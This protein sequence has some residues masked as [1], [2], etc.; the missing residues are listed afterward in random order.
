MCWQRRQRF[1]GGWCRKA[2]EGVMK[3]QWPRELGKAQLRT[4][5]VQGRTFCFCS[6]LK[7]LSEGRLWENILIYT[8]RK[9]ERGESHPGTLLQLLRRSGRRAHTL[10]EGSYITSGPLVSILRPRQHAR[11][12]ASLQGGHRQGTWHRQE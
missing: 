7:L 1:G 5:R 8:H 10:S 6:R 2:E 11:C 4:G 3:M 12:F 9:T